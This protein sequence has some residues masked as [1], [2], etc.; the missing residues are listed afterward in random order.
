MPTTPG[1][2]LDTV[3]P[4]LLVAQ[5]SDAMIFADTKGT[6]KFW[7]HGAERIFGH[8]A[9]DVVGGPLDIIIPEKL[10]GA[11]HNGFDHAMS[12]GEM[13]YVNKVLTTR[14]IRK[15]GTTIYVD[16]SFDMIRDA[17][18]NILGALAIARDCTERF[19]A[20]RAQRVKVSE[21]EKAVADKAT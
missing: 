20:E 17:A 18:G 6:I 9:N 21:L 13:K 1:T 7:N 12:S 19:N 8:A 14:S 15:D 4:S 2:D 3:L 10:L 16:M 11:H 5:T